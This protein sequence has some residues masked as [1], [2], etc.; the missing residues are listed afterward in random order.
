MAKEA[1]KP[2]QYLNV[3]YE[4]C[5]SRMF[6]DIFTSVTDI[7]SVVTPKHFFYKKF[8][9][10]RTQ[11][12]AML[13]GSYLH[14]LV[15]EPEKVSKRY[16]ILDKKNAPFPD[17]DYRNPEN[18]AW[19][20]RLENST[21]GD[22]ITGEQHQQALDMLKSI[23]EIPNIESILHKDGKK[24]EKVSAIIHWDSEDNVIGIY[25]YTPEKHMELAINKERYMLIRCKYDYKHQSNLFGLD[26][27]SCASS[28]PDDFVRDAYTM[29]Y[30]LQGAMSLDII[31]ANEGVKIEQFYFLTCETEA[32]HS[33]D[34]YAMDEELIGL[35]R[36]TYQNRLL[37]IRKS[38]EANHFG[39]YGD[40]FAPQ[41]NGILTLSKPKWAKENIY[42]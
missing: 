26:L 10:P 30:H 32:P 19:K 29:G 12:P 37:K 36:R 7:N 27:K 2:N 28:H 22:V 41:S 25:K 13:F 3:P 20:E 35:G 5:I 38:I 39:G 21:S 42:W 1:E 24:E 11:T 8:R 34:V 15:L 6:Q 17:K 16:I 23:N 31:S 40:T 9:K 18:K 14:T 4:E 33:A